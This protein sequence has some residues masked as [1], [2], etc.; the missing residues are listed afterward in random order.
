MSSK[1]KYPKYDWLGPAVT[2]TSEHVYYSSLSI[3]SK[4]NSF[5]TVNLNDC[6]LL[7][8]T[9]SS[10]T[11]SKNKKKKANEFFIAKIYQMYLSKDQ[12]Q[13]DHK[14]IVTNWFYRQCTAP[15]SPLCLAFRLPA[16]SPLPSIP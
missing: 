4:A 12:Q 15:L 11:S 5:I 7:A 13:K 6:V 9:S 14:I 10:S 2:E 1:G 3:E 8:A 16:S